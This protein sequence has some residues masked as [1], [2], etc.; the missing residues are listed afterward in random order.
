M[1]DEYK[2]TCKNCGKIWYSLVEREEKLNP[3]TPGQNCCNEDQDKTGECGTCGNN[4]AQAQYRHNLQYRRD[5]LE[6][7][8]QCPNCL[9]TNFVEEIVKHEVE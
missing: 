3:D 6:K 1:G 7:L 8:R 5:N 4:G 2:R 9:S